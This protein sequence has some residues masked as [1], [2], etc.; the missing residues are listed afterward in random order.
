[1]TQFTIYPAIDLRNG[2]V[3]RLS[4]GDPQRQTVYGDDPFEMARRW[5]SEGATWLHVVNLDGAFG[6]S[7]SVNEAAISEILKAGLRVQY[8]GGMRDISRIQRAL[9]AGVAR[10]VI[11]TAA[12]EDPSLIDVAMRMF[13]AEKVAVG[14]DARAGKVKTR[15]W[16]Q[17]SKL[18]AIELGRRIFAQGVH[19][20]VFTDIER[21]GVSTG[22][23]LPATARLAQ[24]TGLQVIAS[25]GVASLRDVEAAAQ[26][27]LPGIII[28]RAL[29][30]GAFTLPSA[31]AFEQ[32]SA[33][34]SLRG[35]SR[36][37]Q[38][39]DDGKS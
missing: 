5:Q 27:G 11:G 7:A 18:D 31:L 35:G 36:I 3:V 12:I 6:E 16:E 19:W 30:E 29:Y 15:G 25:G 33:E 13:T 38:S 1:M 22:V 37:P 10:V 28:G 8:G 24:E 9:D 20:C 4:Q 32:E 2:K 17:D 34:R 26:A 14:I 39:K 23:N 21:D